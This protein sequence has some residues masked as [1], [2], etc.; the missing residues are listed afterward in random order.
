M[1]EGGVTDDGNCWEESCISSTLGH[2]DA[3]S[4]IDT[5]AECLERRQCAEGIA[6]DVAKD[7][8]VGIF[9]QH[10]I[11]CS[12]DIAVSATLTELWGTTR[13]ILRIVESWTCWLAECF[14][15]TVGS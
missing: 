2:R 6:T 5:T 15:N 7:A 8:I 11:Q 12:I 10:L 3:G 4:H 13:E 14:G 1:G 9:S